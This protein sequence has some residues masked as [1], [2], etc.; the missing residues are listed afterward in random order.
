MDT[1]SATAVAEAMARAGAAPH[2]PSG[3]GA[4]GAAAPGPRFD[5]ALLY[6]AAAPAPRPAKGRPSPTSATCWA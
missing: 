5:Q 1:V 2:R 3:P 4:A 6:A